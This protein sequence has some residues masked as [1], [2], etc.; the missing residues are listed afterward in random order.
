MQVEKDKARTKLRRK[1]LQSQVKSLS[2]GTILPLGFKSWKKLAV[3]GRVVWPGRMTW[4]WE[5]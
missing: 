5:P 2:S 1:G 3:G 4:S